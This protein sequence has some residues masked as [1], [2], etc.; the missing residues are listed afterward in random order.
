MT[1]N[2]KWLIDRAKA[3]RAAANLGMTSRKP[4]LGD[5]PIAEI[6]TL[7][8]QLRAETARQVAV[9]NETFGGIGGFD[10]L[11]VTSDANIIGVQ[12]F[13]SRHLTVRLYR[14]QLGLTEAYR[15]VGGVVRTGRS[16]VKIVVTTAGELTFNF[17]TVQAAA[18]S[19][20]RR[21]ID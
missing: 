19:L 4:R 1:F 13:D 14:E 2:D 7:W 20:L 9:Y 21:M 11:T 18:G 10:A 15:D 8:D 12:A 5:A 17:A 16:R 3:K 6:D